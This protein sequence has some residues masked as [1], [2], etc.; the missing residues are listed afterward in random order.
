[1]K[2]SVT[3]AG[4]VAG[5][6]CF[7]AVCTYVPAVEDA[8]S[9]ALQLIPDGTNA[10]IGSLFDLDLAVN[11]VLSGQVPVTAYIVLRTPTDDWYSFVSRPDGSFSLAKGIRPAAT[12]SSIPATTISL[13]SA[14]L[15]A[16]T[17][18]GQYWIAA[19]VFPQGANITLDNWKEI[20]IG[21]Y[22][23]EVYLTLSK[24][25]DVHAGRKLM[26]LVHGFSESPSDMD[27]YYNRLKERLPAGD[28][29][30]EKVTE[31]DA[32]FN[33]SSLTGPD[34]NTRR[35]EEFIK[36]K[37]DKEVSGLPDRSIYFLGHSMGGL[38]SRQFSVWHPEKVA[39][40]F[41]LGTPNG[42]M[43]GLPAYSWANRAN[44]TTATASGPAWNETNR[45]QPG[46]MHVIFVGTC[47]GPPA[48]LVEEVPND[49]VVGEWSVRAIEDFADPEA[50]LL[51]YSFAYG[52]SPG[53]PT[54]GGCVT[55]LLSDSEWGITNLILSF[56][57]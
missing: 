47:S 15:Q 16:T 10:T 23:D 2:R 20:A 40:I 26:L 9:T 57:P 3:A 13:F 43:N 18:L 37:T 4:A 12:A 34:S 44:M 49:G 45:A 19:G 17:P 53:S 28:W 7:V 11:D 1:M 48:T 24:E 29:N 27:T 39:K 55:D 54:T 36:E 30:I 51:F 14:R 33:A 38:I 42:G 46:V 32:T 21:S 5:F 6:L 31:L 41:Q 8:Q 25:T 22:K 35:I 56:L 50:L 52:H